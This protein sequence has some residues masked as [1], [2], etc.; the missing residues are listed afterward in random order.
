MRGLPRTVEGTEP[1][2]GRNAVDD[3]LRDLHARFRVLRGDGEGEVDDVGLY[4]L[5]ESTKVILL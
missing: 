4:F 5:D 2:T 1:D 3:C